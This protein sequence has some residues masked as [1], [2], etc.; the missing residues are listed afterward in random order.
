M[1]LL[2][3]QPPGIYICWVTPTSKGFFINEVVSPTLIRCIYDGYSKELKQ[4]AFSEI[5]LKYASYTRITHVAD[6]DI[7]IDTF[8]V[9]NYP[10]WFI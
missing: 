6:I 4:Y 1:K 3:D 9:S 8:D 7:D 5:D 2:S 10:E